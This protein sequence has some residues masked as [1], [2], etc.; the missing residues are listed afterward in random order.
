M[1]DDG[2]NTSWDWPIPPERGTRQSLLSFRD[3]LL[4]KVEQHIHL[5]ESATE[6]YRKNIA[7]IDALLA[8]T[9][10]DE[11]M[12]VF[13]QLEVAKIANRAH[14]D[15]RDVEIFLGAIRTAWAP[16]RRRGAASGGFFATELCEQAH[17]TILA[18]KCPWCQKDVLF[19][20]L[21][22]TR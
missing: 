4:E 13:Q 15:V 6:H 7:I 17:R 1:S 14:V 21:S 20:D 5:P 16:V 11:A 19:V 22:A 8:E 3:S 9:G 2:P 10:D 18:G 12:I